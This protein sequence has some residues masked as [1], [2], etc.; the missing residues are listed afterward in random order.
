MPYAWEKGMSKSRHTELLMKRKSR[1]EGTRIQARSSGK[2][3]I[4]QCVD[5]FSCGKPISF[6]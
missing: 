2:L 5:G 6:L 3:T 4:V 1:N